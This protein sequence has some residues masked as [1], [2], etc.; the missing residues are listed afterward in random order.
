[1]STQTYTLCTVSSIVGLE[2]E[3]TRSYTY[4][5]ISMES[6]GESKTVLCIGWYKKKKKIKRER[7][8]GFG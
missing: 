3:S 2:I 4:N 1:M 6:V 5:Y 8:G 7:V